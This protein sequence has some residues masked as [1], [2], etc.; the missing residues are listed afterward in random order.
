MKREEKVFIMGEKS[1]SRSKSASARRSNVK[2]GV[3]SVSAVS[4]SDTVSGR[5]KRSAKRD[6][7]SKLGKVKDEETAWNNNSSASEDGS[8]SPRV[9][10]QRAKDIDNCSS[11]KV[12]YTAY[13]LAALLVFITLYVY[14]RNQN[15]IID[16][17]GKVQVSYV[18]FY[19]W[20]TAISTGLGVLPFFFVSE[21]N[22][23]WKGASNAL[24]VGMMLAASYSLAYEGATLSIDEGETGV[25]DPK[26]M[27]GGMH[28]MGA[29]LK[30]VSGINIPY[31]HCLAA[32]DTTLARTVFGAV[33]G[34]VFIV[35]TGKVLASREDDISIG[36]VVGA[37]AAK[38]VL[39][40]FVM[41]LHSL[42]EGIGIGVSFG[43]KSL[44]LGHFISTSLAVHN[45]PEGL[46]VALVLFPMGISKLR[47]VLWAIFTSLPQ[48]LMAVPSF[49][50]VKEFLPL[51]PMGLGFASGAMGYVSLFELLPDAIEG[52]RSWPHVLF[53][54][55]L[56]CVCM[57]GLQE[58]VHNVV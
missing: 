57:L 12:D 3:D 54:A 10:R 47:A 39:I 6:S 23:F 41:T 31:E 1:R 58:L 30:A 55:T 7:V 22:D 38:M 20:V 56:A 29:R 53:I 49:L 9:I 21:P 51:L 15:M 27:L 45:I 8:V 4:N 32:L 48:P 28:H 40:V 26:G 36:N 35:V 18:F 52:V 50:F 46:A 5:S 16:A 11:N 43:G 17:S 19:G 33:L 42:T 13:A 24:A 37:S 25:F 34:V 14:P 2:N 44:H